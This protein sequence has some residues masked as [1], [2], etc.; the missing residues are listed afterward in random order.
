MYD[1]LKVGI[2]KEDNRQNAAFLSNVFGKAQLF[3]TE[4]IKW[5]YADHPMGQVLGYNAILNNQIASHFVLQPFP[6]LLN[7]AF[8]KGLLAFNTA[9][10]KDHR[11]KGL[12]VRLARKTIDDAINQGCEFVVAVTNHNSK[13]GFIK[14][15]G[16]QEVCQ[17]QTKLGVGRAETKSLSNEIMFEKVWNTDLINWRLANPLRKYFISNGKVYSKTH[18]S[19]VKAL[20][21]CEGGPIRY[22]SKSNWHPVTLYIGLDKNVSFSKGF[23]FNIPEKL[24][25]SPL[26]LIFRDLI[27]KSFRLDKD[28]IRFNLID[29]DAY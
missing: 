4:Y 23:F 26:F 10:H 1:F 20:L 25:P 16:F 17:L 27:N 5:Q 12:F 24:K 22:P 15:L 7:G 11:G 6:A 9:T 14:H 3:T 2:A 19:L 18:L 21:S 28:M 8:R 13:P 29:F